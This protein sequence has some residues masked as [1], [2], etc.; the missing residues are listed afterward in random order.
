MCSDPQADNGEYK[1]K[2]I[3]HEFKDDKIIIVKKG[4]KAIYLSFKNNDI[5]FLYLTPEDI[6]IL[7]KEIGEKVEES[8]PAM[9]VERLSEILGECGLTGSTTYDMT[10]WA[11]LRAFISPKLLKRCKI[12]EVGK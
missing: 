3:E 5:P 1:M 7:A 9:T 12:R 2:K 10:T 11:E 8:T 6:K 4:S